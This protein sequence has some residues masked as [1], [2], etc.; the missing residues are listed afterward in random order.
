MRVVGFE[1]II[2][3]ID[4]TLADISHRLHYIK[5]VEKKDWD[6]F[7]IL[8]RFDEVKKDIKALYKLCYDSGYNIAIVTGRFNKYR[9]VTQNWLWMN[10]I[11]FDELYMRPDGNFQSDNS[12]KEEIFNNHFSDRHIRF[13]VDDRDRVVEMW[14][15]KG[16]T[17]LQCQKGDY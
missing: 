1:W 6:S 13:V 2:F 12:I 11:A 9:T 8:M 15:S 3:D 16:L 17:V 7:N 5:D 10:G 4:G 14:R